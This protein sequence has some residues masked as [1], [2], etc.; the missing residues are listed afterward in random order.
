MADRRR[1]SPLV[2]R[3]PR[4]EAQSGANLVREVVG[5]RI[6][7]VGW[8]ANLAG[9]LV[10]GGS[11]LFLIPV[12]LDPDQTADFLLLNAPVALVY[13]L[14][15]GFVITRHFRRVEHS[16]EWIVEGRAPDER[17]H[18]LALGL[19]MHEVKASALAWIGAGICSRLSTRWR[20]RGGLRQW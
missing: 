18:R 11:V 13:Y 2:V 6:P 19:A 10:I 8:G 3:A 7:W 15:V 4:G 14:L 16:L 1:G 20:S 5:R 9:I 17:E 12:F